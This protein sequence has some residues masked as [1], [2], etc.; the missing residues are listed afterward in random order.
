MFQSEQVAKLFAALAQFQEEIR[1]PARVST[2]PFFDSKYTSLDAMIEHCRPV[3]AKYGLAVTQLPDGHQLTTIL[4]HV[5]GEHMGSSMDMIVDKK[6]MQGLGSAITYS[7][8]Y[9]YAA[10]LGIASEDDDDGNASVN[11]PAGNK[12]ADPFD[13]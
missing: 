13:L 10:I 11:K 2:N 5:S 8:R 9:A 3:L 4:A 6:N 1:N 7:R 12:S